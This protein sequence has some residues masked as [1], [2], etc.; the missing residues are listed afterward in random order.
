MNFIP[1]NRDLEEF[2]DTYV[3]NDNDICSLSANHAALM[4][5]WLARVQDNTRVKRHVYICFDL[6]HY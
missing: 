5:N 4:S 2:E 1:T 6:P 3:L